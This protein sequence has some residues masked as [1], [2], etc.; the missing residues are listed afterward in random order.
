MINR[1]T[2]PI[3]I[4]SYILLAL[5]AI[6]ILSTGRYKKAYITLKQV[7]A[8][9]EISRQIFKDYNVMKDSFHFELPDSWETEELS[10]TGGEVLY[11]LSFVSGDEKIKGFVQ[12][13]EIAEPLKQFVDKS[14]KS[15]TGVVDF[16]YFNIEEIRADNKKGFLLDYSRANPEGEYNRGYEALIEGNS[17]NM[18]RLSFFVPEKD[19]EDYYEILF[20]N[21]IR[22]IRIKMQ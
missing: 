16:K 6:V 13:W 17:N 4:L 21:I 19:W 15:A 5:I 8:A 20:D 1:R 3:I 18:Y 7:I 11:H 12:V 22:R 14:K 2:K 9:E 10:F